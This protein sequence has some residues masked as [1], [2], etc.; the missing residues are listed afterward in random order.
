MGTHDQSHVL[1]RLCP[2]R[3]VS[4]LGHHLNGIDWRLFVTLTY[5]YAVH[6]LPNDYAM[7]RRKAYFHSFIVQ[8]LKGLKLWPRKYAYYLRTEFGTNQEM[9]LHLLFEAEGLEEYSFEELQCYITHLWSHQFDKLPRSD[10]IEITPK[11]Q[12]HWVN[13]ITEFEYD[14]K[15]LYSDY[16]DFQPLGLRKR[17]FKLA[18]GKTPKELTLTA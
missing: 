10:V 15:G 4:G 5:P 2:D 3:I 11:T 12:S 9:H 18:E 17:L 6:R 7:G 1:S 16:I 8:F 13:Y 14:Q